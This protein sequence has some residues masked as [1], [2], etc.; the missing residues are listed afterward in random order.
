MSNGNLD[1]KEAL[2]LDELSRQVIHVISQAFDIPGPSLENWISDKPESPVSHRLL[3][4]TN[5]LATRL[6]SRDT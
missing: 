5:K 4:K 2:P 3:C 6:Y 1:L